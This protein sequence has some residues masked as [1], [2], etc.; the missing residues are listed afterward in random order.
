MLDM[1]E[2]REATSRDEDYLKHCI[3]E[4]YHEFPR[5]LARGERTLAMAAE[6]DLERIGAGFAYLAV[7]DGRPVGAAWWIPEAGPEDV[8]VAY[9][10]EP[11]SR[12]QGV[13]T[14]LLA[15]GVEEGR[16]RGVRSMTI[17]THPGNEASIAL[18]HKAGF[19]PVVTLLRQDLKNE[20]E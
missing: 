4:A 20:G 8:T 14:R 1:I 18:A 3:Q 11:D 9:Y 12:G 15:H 13:A 19:Q 2:L 17:K 5:L 10:V 16:R 7:Q 6:H